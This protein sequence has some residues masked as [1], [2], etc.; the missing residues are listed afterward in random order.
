MRNTD[1]SILEAFIFRRGLS[2]QLHGGG[3]EA[4]FWHGAEKR[5]NYQAAKKALHG[6]K[7]TPV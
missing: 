7:G 1:K 4:N 3:E 5:E 2:P 6:W